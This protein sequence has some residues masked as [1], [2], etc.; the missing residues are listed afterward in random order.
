MSPDQSATLVHK[1]SG[2]NALRFPKVKCCFDV[3]VV[4]CRQVV[5]ESN[6][7]ARLTRVSRL[8]LSYLRD[9][10]ALPNLSAHLKFVIEACSSK[11]T[12][13]TTG[14][15]FFLRYV[16]YQPRDHRARKQSLQWSG[17]A[18]FSGT[19][20]L[21]AENILRRKLTLSDRTL[22]EPGKVCQEFTAPIANSH[23]EAHFAAACL[24]KLRTER[25]RELLEFRIFQRIKY[26]PE[27][28]KGFT[29]ISSFQV[30]TSSVVVVSQP[31]SS[32]VFAYIHDE[33]YNTTSTISQ[34]SFLY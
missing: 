30:G 15:T 14:I 4:V 29:R 19:L 33:K 34:G 16:L 25:G 27:P 6:A 5:S 12:A 28:P 23:L 11:T 32:Y 2:T 1:H 20:T 17:A 21:K 18:I 22:F 26:I 24:Q 9:T 8:P 3:G 7:C 13:V 31:T 10:A